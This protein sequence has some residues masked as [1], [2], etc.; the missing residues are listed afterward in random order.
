MTKILQS[1]RA[2]LKQ[3]THGCRPDMHEPDEQGLSAKVYGDHLDNACGEH[4]TIEHGFQEY[5]V[6]LS[7]NG[8]RETF[9]LA[10]LIAMARKAKNV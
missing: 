1:D 4:V 5:I 9:N 8:K 2:R 3:I 6:V 7:R 10:N